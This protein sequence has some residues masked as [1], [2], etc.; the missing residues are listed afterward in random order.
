VDGKEDVVEGAGKKDV[1]AADEVAELVCMKGSGDKDCGSWSG[2]W[3]MVRGHSTAGDTASCRK[4]SFAEVDSM[5]R[6][7][8]FNFS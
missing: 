7:I 6:S 8:A 2:S 5:Q 1:V 3:M 4:G